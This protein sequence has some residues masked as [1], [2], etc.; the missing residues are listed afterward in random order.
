MDSMWE[1]LIDNAKFKRL[2]SPMHKRNIHDQ[3][4]DAA[5]PCEE[6]TGLYILRLQDH[7]RMEERTKDLCG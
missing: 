2:R 7:I 4:W 3:G 1:S 5:K 6:T